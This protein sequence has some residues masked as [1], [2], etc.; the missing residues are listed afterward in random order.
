MILAVGLLGLTCFFCVVRMVHQSRIILKHQVDEIL[1]EGRRARREGPSQPVPDPYAVY[2][3]F[4]KNPA[5]LGEIMPEPR[6]LFGA[7]W[8]S[9][10]AREARNDG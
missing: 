7:E 1:R 2:N 6:N 3:L 5:M 9:P 10:P 8:E 4:K